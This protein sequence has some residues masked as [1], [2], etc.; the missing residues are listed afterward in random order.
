MSNKQASKAERWRGGK[1]NWEKGK[2]GMWRECTNDNCLLGSN[3]PGGFVCQISGLLEGRSTTGT[4]LNRGLM[5]SCPGECDFEDRSA[6]TRIDKIKV[7][8]I[9]KNKKQQSF[10]RQNS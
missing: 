3:Y 8:K 5:G 9:L 10:P 2:K 6:Q 7:M 4:R 1:G